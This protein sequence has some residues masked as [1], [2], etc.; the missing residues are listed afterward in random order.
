MVYA[1][2]EPIFLEAGGMSVSVLRVADHMRLAAN[3]L[4]TNDQT[5]EADPDLVGKVVRAT[6]RGIEDTITDPSGAYEIAM[7]YMPDAGGV[8]GGAGA[9]KDEK[10]LKVLQETVKLMQ[11]MAGDP[12]AGQP[13]GWTDAAVWNTTQDFLFEAKLIPQKGDVEEMFTNDFIKR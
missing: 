1:A 3:G 11:P 7:T 2:N 8:S 9:V 6:L 13:L 5:I 4:A 12:A 10:Q